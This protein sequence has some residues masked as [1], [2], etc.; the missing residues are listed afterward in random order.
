MQKKSGRTFI[1]HTVDVPLEIRRIDGGDH[2]ERRGRDVSFGGLSFTSDE[3]LR[4]G[5]SLE[6][7]M[8]SVV[9]PFEARAKVVWCRTEGTRFLVGVQFLDPTDAFRSRM[10]EQVCAI[11]NYR[12]R[13]AQR[14]GRQLTS[15]EA[16]AEWIERYAGRFPD[17]SKN[18]G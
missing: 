7:R 13:V 1:R 15:R 6:L 4:P 12:N 14:E 16:A 3:R 2:G 8:P 9:P 11:E 10:V 5:D 18:H 17:S